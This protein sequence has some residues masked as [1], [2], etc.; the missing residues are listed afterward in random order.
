MDFR[1]NKSTN[2]GDDDWT[3][4][5]MSAF[6]QAPGSMKEM[7]QLGDEPTPEVAPQYTPREIQF[8]VTYPKPGGGDVQ[9]SLTSRIMT[10]EERL[11]VARMVARAA[12]VPV[13]QLAEADRL[14]VQALAHC[15]VQLREPPE[16]FEKYA[17]EDDELLFSVF[18]ITQQHE[19]QFFRRSPLE[20]AGDQDLAVILID[21]PMLARAI[22]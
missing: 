20:S 9:W 10:A 18:A 22:G 15:A 3:D 16:D 5:A 7:R 2:G 12:V 8:S 14:R 21:A 1:P 4:K 11:R 19:A 13:D 17:T 6:E